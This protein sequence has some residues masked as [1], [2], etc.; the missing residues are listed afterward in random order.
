MALVKSPLLTGAKIAANRANA[1]KST[2]PRTPAGKRRV[3]L[4]ALKHGR[5]SRAFRD[6]LIKA[7]ADVEVLDWI[8]A[9]ILD[10]FGPLAAR[11]R[12]GAERLAREVW[13]CYSVASGLRGIPGRPKGLPS[14]P[15][16]GVE[17]TDSSVMPLSPIGARF[18]I[19]D[20]RKERRLVFWTRGRLWVWSNPNFP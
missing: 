19:E 5:R 7:G 8:L 18:R 12:R 9:H 1:A 6:S 3:V 11:E 10:C 13:C 4:N 17:S 2:G 14:K 16:Y 15:R 20:P